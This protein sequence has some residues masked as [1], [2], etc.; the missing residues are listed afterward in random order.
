MDLTTLGKTSETPGGRRLL[1][2]GVSALLTVV[3]CVVVAVGMMAVSLLAGDASPPRLTLPLPAEEAS[4]DGRLSVSAPAAVDEA[5][6]QVLLP[7]PTAGVASQQGRT[8]PAS[9]ESS[10]WELPGGLAPSTAAGPAAS[11][12]R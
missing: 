7:T 12:Y 5:A 11:R 4:G 9:A 3:T 2:V 8:P 1:G 10:P 6:P